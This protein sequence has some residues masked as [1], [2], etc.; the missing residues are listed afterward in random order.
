MQKSMIFQINACQSGAFPEMVEED[1]DESPH[2]NVDETDEEVQD[3]CPALDD[4]L[5][6]DIDDITIE[7][8]DRVLMTMVQPVDPHH[9]V[10]ASSTVS[11]RLAE[12]FAKNSKLKDFHD[13]VLTFLHAY[14]DVFSETAFDSLPER[15]KWDHAIELERKTSPGFCKVYPLTLTGQMEMDA[16]LEE[17]LATGHI[18]QSK[19]PLG[20]PVFFI[21]KKDRK[22]RFVQDYRA[23]NAI[24]RKDRYL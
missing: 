13:I 8:G 18:R 3:T 20:A 22:L 14:A 21:K 1:E 16:F 5:N 4:D 12:A 19:S 17:A 6:S 15:C 2:V 7:E 11:G 9:F 10:H 23:L 24:T